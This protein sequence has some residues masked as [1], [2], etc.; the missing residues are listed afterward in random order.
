[1]SVDYAFIRIILL[2]E[3]HSLRG[4]YQDSLEGAYQPLRI[5]GSQE[6]LRS[7]ECRTLAEVWMSALENLQ[8]SLKRDACQMLLCSDREIEP[9]QRALP[10]PVN[11][12]PWTIQTLAGAI[13][14]ARG[15]CR[16]QE[17]L[18]VTEW[19]L[20]G[21][22]LSNRYPKWFP[23]G[24]DGRSRTLYLYTAPQLDI[25]EACLESDISPIC[26]VYQEWIRQKSG[27]KQLEKVRQT[28]QVS[29]VV[30]ALREYNERQK[31]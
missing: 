19:R 30:Q 24:Q 20:D 2:R 6:L 17:I 1:M 29:P 28:E 12:V 23:R 26:R 5:D 21:I 8:V 16:G 10:E 7:G 22:D 25:P 18:S 27:A 3:D 4:F 14:A 9:E 15:L 11:T 31:H 13:R